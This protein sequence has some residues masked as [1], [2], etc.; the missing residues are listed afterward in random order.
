M[1][2]LITPDDLES[3]LRDLDGWTLVDDGTAIEKE[4]LFKGFNAAFGFMSRVALA[5]E[6]RNHHPEWS[7]VYNRV[8]I[9]WS[10]HSEGGV[11]ELDLKLARSCEAFSAP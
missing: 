3:A 5:A 10:T 8:V 1:P 11:T 7:N 9:R 4:Y 2:D 6:R